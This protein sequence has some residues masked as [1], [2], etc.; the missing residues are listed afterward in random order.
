LL[1][2]SCTGERD[3]AEEVAGGW[4]VLDCAVS[5]MVEAASSAAIGKQRRR[6]RR[7]GK[8]PKKEEGMRRIGCARPRELCKEAVTERRPPVRSPAAVVDIKSD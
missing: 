8:G 2:A 5:G 7:K 4:L 6:K 1:S 3:G